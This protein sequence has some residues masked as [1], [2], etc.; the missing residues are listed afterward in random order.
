[1]H[2]TH[3]ALTVLAIFT[4][5]ALG[6]MGPQAPQVAY[7]GPHLVTDQIPQPYQVPEQTPSGPVNLLPNWFLLQ[8]PQ[9]P[10]YLAESGRV[11]QLDPTTVTVTVN[12]RVL[13]ARCDGY[14]TMGCPTQPDYGLVPLNATTALIVLNPA[15]WQAGDKVR[16]SYVYVSN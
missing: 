4:L 7:A 11:F 13:T 3:R 6:Q 2:T 5:A 12:G 15:V 8:I 1:M 10:A 16:V 14:G 9:V